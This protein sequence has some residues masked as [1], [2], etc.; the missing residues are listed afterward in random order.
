MFTQEDFLAKID[1]FIKRNGISPTFFGKEALGDPSFIN[2]LRVGKRSPHL[3]TIK[4][5]EDFMCDYSKPRQTGGA[6]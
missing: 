4:K 6:A 1:R 3:R 5:V 2:D